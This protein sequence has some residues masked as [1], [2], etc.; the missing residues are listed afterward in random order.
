MGFDLHGLKP[1]E[2]TKKPEVLIK[3]QYGYQIEDETIRKKWYN[4]YEKWEKENPGVY[5]RNNVWWWRPLWMYVCASCEDILTEEDMSKGTWNDGHK[6]SKTKSKRI[7]ARLRKLIKS[8]K[9]EGFD[10]NKLRLTLNNLRESNVSINYYV[11]KN[12][13]LNSKFFKDKYTYILNKSFFNQPKEIVF[14]SFAK[15]LRIIGLK[16]Y[17]SRGKSISFTINKISGKFFY[18]T[19]FFYN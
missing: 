15:I 4:A 6:I 3:H 18:K 10:E 14:R 16:Y 9:E 12:I 8:M 7:A 1:Q 13:E 17:N 2:N 5:F 11:R 19:T